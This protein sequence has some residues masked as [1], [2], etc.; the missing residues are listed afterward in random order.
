MC[1]NCPTALA[2][3]A[4]DVA[5][6]DELLAVLKAA[7]LWADEC[8]EQCVQAPCVPERIRRI[9]VRLERVQKTTG[10]A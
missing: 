3:A 10:D 1:R 2:N 5:S 4:V 8:N 7:L 9:I 6:V